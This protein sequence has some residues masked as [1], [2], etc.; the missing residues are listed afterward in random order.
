MYFAYG[1]GFRRPEDF[2]DSRWNEQ[3]KNPLLKGFKKI[4]GL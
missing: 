4:F 2:I 3:T 1:I